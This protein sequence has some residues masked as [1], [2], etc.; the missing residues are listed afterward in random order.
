MKASGAILGGDMKLTATLFL[1]LFVF[2]ILSGQSA[3]AD[4]YLVTYK[5]SQ[6]F[7]AAEPKFP[8]G[9]QVEQKLIHLGSVIV[10]VDAPEQVAILE[11]MSSVA[12]VEKEV[13]HPLPM[14][15]HGYN[16]TP[17]WNFSLEYSLTD[18][19]TELLASKSKLGKNTPWGIKTVKAQ[20]AWAVAGKGDGIRVAVLD[21][22]IDENHPA[23]KNNIE[24]G[25]DFI[26]DE[27]G[28][29]PYADHIG[30]GTHVAGTIA[31]VQSSTGFT[32]VAP[33]AKI[34]AGRVCYEEG[35]PNLAVAAAI[36]WAIAERVDVINLSLGGMF[37][38][39]MEK[40]AI[41]AAEQAGIIVVA[42]SGNSGTPQVGFPAALPT[43]IAVGA[44]SE[45]LKKA[46]FS[47]YGPELDVM[48]PGVG[49]ESSVPLGSGRESEVKMKTAEGKDD[50]VESTSFTGSAV[51]GKG[52][53]KPVVFVG[54]AKADD[55]AGKS[56]K[57]HFALIQRGEIT[58]AEKVKNALAAD[59]EG[60]VV[61]NNEPGLINGSI[62][63]DG[64]V[65]NIPVVMVTKETGEKAKA[66]LQAGSEVA[67]S[68]RIETTDYASFSGTSMAS[69]HVAGVV[70][71]IRAA[72]PKITPAEV[73]DLL[74][75]TAHD[76]GQT[77][78]NETGSGL[79]DAEK[80][81]TE[82]AKL[83]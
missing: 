1:T 57:G 5:K 40:D 16:L 74:K 43:A 10:N 25:Q 56:L 23:L 24:K 52:V 59:A 61:F 31:A 14:P 69:P 30:H 49:V 20:E 8:A 28:P 58:F 67:F 22:G 18:E 53:A 70:A 7:S 13:I 80:A 46:N 2:L 39:V 81:V 21:T 41:A 72:N 15:V 36:N 64:S 75:R 47:Q 65:L 73:R 78:K 60:V 44:I 32:G 48:A 76:L 26:I 33:K 27:N 38:T 9:V 83:R 77:P 19:N 62:S 12:R 51:V 17:S 66:A 54:L 37:S 55:L 11:K 34:L 4:R 82:A 71:L 68:I 79:V 35:C 42:A 6:F 3:V 50:V 29:Y 45:D 63:E